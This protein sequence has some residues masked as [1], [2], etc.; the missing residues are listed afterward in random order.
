MPTSLDNG[1]LFLISTL[2]D[3]Y[4]MI[5]GVRLILC[6]T[7][8][9]YFNPLS[10]VIAKLT[11][12]IIVPLRRIFPTYAN[13]ELATVIVMLLLEGIKFLL[14]SLLTMGIPHAAGII[15]LSLADMIKLVVNTFFYAILLQAILSWVQQNHSPLGELLS[16]ITTP[17]LRPLHRI[18]PPLGGLDITPIPAMILLQ[19]I[20]IVLVTPLSQLGMGML[21]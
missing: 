20:N 1:T 21:F 6:W 7:R 10:Q 14:L 16:Q 11:H 9:N 3:L 8:A 18:I 19:L 13:I 15:L 12:P 5:L 17:I 4:L 2:F